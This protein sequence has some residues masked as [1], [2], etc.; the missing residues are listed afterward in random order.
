MAQNTIADSEGPR[1]GSSIVGGAAH[2]LGLNKG[3][4][5][6]EFFAPGGLVPGYGFRDSVPAMLT[7]GEFVLN[8]NAV[9]ALG[10]QTLRAVNSSPRAAVAAAGGNAEYVPIVNQ[11][12]LNG[13]VLSEGVTRYAL[14]KKRGQG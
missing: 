8:R 2:L 6:P 13:R 4:L 7:P 3:G 5:V 11:V 14:R 9:S 12:V 1:L 10:V